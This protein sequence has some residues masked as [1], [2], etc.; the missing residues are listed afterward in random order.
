MVECRLPCGGIPTKCLPVVFLG[1][2]VELYLLF[3]AM[4]PA[5]LADALLLLRS[6]PQLL[7]AIPVIG[8]MVEYGFQIEVNGTGDACGHIIVKFLEAPCHPYFLVAAEVRALLPCR[9]LAEGV[10]DGQPDVLRRGVLCHTVP[11]AVFGFRASGV[12]AQCVLGC[13]IV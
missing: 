11:Q 13:L 6:K 8:R 1:V 12:E 4:L 5:Y 2:P 9:R 10:D 7:V 3:P